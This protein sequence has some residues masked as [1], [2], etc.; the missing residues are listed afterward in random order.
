[1]ASGWPKLDGAALQPTAQTLQLWTQV[2]G[3]VRLARTPW[4]NHSWH[5]T[6]YVSA[7]GLTTSLI[8]NGASGVEL[9][10][11]FVASDLVIRTSADAERRVALA[12]KS[13]AAFYAEVLAALD[14]VGAPTRI[15]A[16]PN[17]LPEA[18]PF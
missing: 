4:V 18:I 6:L 15:D 7:R 12:P 5:V 1:M 8:P 10:F 9:E 16:V 3:K 2:V 13:V 11:D 14:A 17:E